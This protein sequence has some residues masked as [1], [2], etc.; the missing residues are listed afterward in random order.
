[1]AVDASEE[2]MEGPDLTSAVLEAAI[3]RCQV[4]MLF[5]LAQKAMA[6]ACLPPQKR[7]QGWVWYVLWKKLLLNAGKAGRRNLLAPGG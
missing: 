4:N 5:I 7:G 1:M 2:P 3:C 6:W